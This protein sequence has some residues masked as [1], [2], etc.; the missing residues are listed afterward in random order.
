MASSD[1]DTYGQLHAKSVFLSQDGMRIHNDNDDSQTVTLKA[2]PNQ[3]GDI[4]LT[5]PVGQ[6]GALLSEHS[7]LDARNLKNLNLVTPEAN[8]ADADKF[9]FVDDSD[10]ESLK[11]CTAS[12]LKTYVGAAAGLSPGDINNANLFTAGVVDSNALA[13]NAV[14][15]AALADNAVDTA[16]IGAGQVTAAKVATDAISTGKIQNDAVTNEK[17]ANDAVQADQ[18][19]NNAVTKAKMADAPSSYG[20]AEASKLVAV[21][22]N[23][24]VASL[25][26]ITAEGTVEAGTSEAF[27][28]GGDTDGSWRIRVNAGNIVFEKKETGSW[29]QKGS[30]AA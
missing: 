17:L 15:S 22:A 30:F 5:L 29:V 4:E 19:Q 24:D 12:Q 1:F 26:H 13:A 7:D 20:T 25:R 2:T 14:D 11:I 27:R 16:A 21:D 9:A 10:S 6:A 18:I 3:G 8:V 23:K 28:L